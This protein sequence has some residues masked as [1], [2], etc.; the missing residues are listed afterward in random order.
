MKDYLVGY[1]GFVGGNIAARHEFTG[2]YNSKNI[3][4]AYGG[5][6]DLLVYAGVRAEMFLAN[7]DPEKDYRTILD[8][9]ENIRKISP[10]KLVLISTIA[11]YNEPDGVNEDDVI[12]EEELSPYGRNRFALEKMV[13]DEFSDA[14]II[15]LPGLY[16]KG[17]KKNFIY[18]FITRIPAMLSEEKYMSLANDSELI[19]TSYEKLENG[20]YRCKKL[21][22]SERAELRECFESIGFTSLNFTDSRGTY[23]Y[24]NLENLWKD[25]NTALKEDIKLLN[26]AVEPVTIRELYYALTGEIFNNELTRTIP[27]FNFKTR[28]DDLFGGRHGYIEQK[29]RIIQDIK[30]FVKAYSEKDVR[31]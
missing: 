2:N 11:V 3:R 19:R 9:M 22:D 8:A 15:R 26:L 4:D 7:K 5:R 6:P 18:D 17:L 28:Y 29:E 31:L 13:R 21:S 27:Y 12:K 10:E 25:I 1:T 14:V 20:F 30:E 23:Q 16:G 24:Y